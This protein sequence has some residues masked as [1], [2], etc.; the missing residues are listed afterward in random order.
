MNLKN[1][2]DKKLWE[3]LEKQYNL[4]KPTGEAGKILEHDIYKEIIRRE[5]ERMEP[6]KNYVCD[7]LRRKKEEYKRLLN[8]IVNIIHEHIEIEIENK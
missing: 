5:K 2:T 4:R 3:M 7:K 1:K 8:D 6:Y